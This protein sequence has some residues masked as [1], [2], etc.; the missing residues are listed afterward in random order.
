MNEIN[1][2][3]EVCKLQYLNMEGIFTHFA[4]ADESDVG[5][6]YTQE[7]FNY[8]VNSID[9]FRQHGVE[10]KIRHCANSAAIFDYPE[11]HLDM[12][13]AGVVLY[14]L[15]PSEK[16]KKLLELK[17]V[18]SLHSVIAHIKIV[19]PGKTISYDRTYM[20]TSN[21]KN[22]NCSYWICRWL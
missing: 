17:C 3:V 4:V 19:M 21:R 11:A 8:F 2:A 6:A 14:G 12:V 1:K 13:R 7:Q 16:V 18:M 10:F 5:K 9:I 15:K 22:S 20:V